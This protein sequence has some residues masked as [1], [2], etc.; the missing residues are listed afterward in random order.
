MP[1]PFSIANIF[2]CTMQCCFL[3]KSS[4]LSH[5]NQFGHDGRMAAGNNGKGGTALYTDYL[6]ISQYP[7]FG[8][9]CLLKIPF[10]FSFL[11]LD[12]MFLLVIPICPASFTAESCGFSERSST[13]FFCVSFLQF[14]PLFPFNILRFT[15]NHSFD[16]HSIL[17]S[18]T[19][20]IAY[21]IKPANAANTP[22]FNGVTIFPFTTW[23]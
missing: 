11:I 22:Q 20:F 21:N 10:S 12:S 6:R 23:S 8:E 1:P 2:Y 3:P 7:L 17:L 4:R 19:F 15:A 16:F 18:L 14:S 5:G 13:I 9:P